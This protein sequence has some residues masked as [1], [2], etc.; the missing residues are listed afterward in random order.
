VGTAYQ[1]YFLAC[2]V[3]ALLLPLAGLIFNLVSDPTVGDLADLTAG[4]VFGAVFISF[5]IVG[6]VFGGA[7]I[8]AL[9][10]FVL[11]RSLLWWARVRSPLGFA[12]AGALNVPLLFFLWLSANSGQGV[13]QNSAKSLLGLIAWLTLG[14]LAGLVCWRVEAR[15]LEEVRLGPSSIPP[16]EA[17]S[18]S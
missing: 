18:R 17:E 8:L 4:D 7:L 3:P 13:D 5:M 15:C 12:L 6:L 14:A 16:A 10:G 2:L 1:G 11:M 9:P